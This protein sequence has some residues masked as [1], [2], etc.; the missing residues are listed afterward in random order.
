VNPISNNKK[1]C[2]SLAFLKEAVEDAVREPDQN[3]DQAQKSQ[4]LEKSQESGTVV[5]NAR[6]DEDCKV[7]IAEGSM[8]SHASS[9]S[10]AVLRSQFPICEVS[11]TSGGIRIWS[12]IHVA[13]HIRS[14]R[15]LLVL[16]PVLI[17]PRLHGLDAFR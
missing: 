16:C 15:V 12:A 2:A 8:P 10:E 4:G 3:S 14:L 11:D 9:V 7:A 1:N 17:C 13:L 6:H 5:R